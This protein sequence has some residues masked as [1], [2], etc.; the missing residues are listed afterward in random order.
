MRGFLQLPEMSQRFKF[1]VNAWRIF[2]LMTNIF[3]LC[4]VTLKNKAHLRFDPLHKD[5]DANYVIDDA[6]EFFDLINNCMNETYKIITK[7]KMK[8]ISI[9]SQILFQK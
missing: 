9:S 6:K 7:L 3:Q 5:I 4:L 2:G 1:E 8:L